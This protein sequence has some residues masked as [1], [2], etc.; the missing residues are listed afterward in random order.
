M[1]EKLPTLID[2]KHLALQGSHL[3]GNVALAQME[4]LKDNLD[5]IGPSDYAYIDWVFTID[6]NRPMIKGYTQAQLP[7]LCQRCLQTMRWPIKNKI[8]M[9]IITKNGKEDE[10]PKDYEILSLTN[11]PVSLVTIIEDELILALPIVA[12]HEKCPTNEYQLPD[13]FSLDNTFQNNPFR[14]LE[15]LKN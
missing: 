5:E 4:R 6:Q 14:V 1:L 10:L 2:P 13:S 8:A 7:I 11:T 3:Q 15:I 9:L 12:L